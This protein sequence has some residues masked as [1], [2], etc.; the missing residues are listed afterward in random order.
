MTHYADTAVIVTGASSGLGQATA[1][2]LA[3]Q[4]RP[5]AV[6][7][8]DAARVEETCVRCREH[9]V[10]P[11]GITLD[12]GKRTAVSKA[13]EESHSELGTIG[14]L[15]MCHGICPLGSI[16]DLD[17]SILEECLNTN[18]TSL[19]FLIEEVLPLLRENQGGSIVGALSTNAIKPEP[20]NAQYSISKHGALG[21]MRV[22]AK[23]LGAE[24]IRVNTV[25]PGAMDTAMMKSALELAGDAAE[26]VKTQMMA[27][28]PLGYIA[29]PAEVAEVVCFLLS[30]KA[31]YVHGAEIA[32]DGGLLL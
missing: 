11:V 21:L 27:E 29:D 6:W 14:G 32:V 20:I 7:G 2:K 12:V 13:V 1:I 10:E 16:G 8:R 15:A 26:Q 9:G 30:E 18:L 4:G 23:T 3:E 28:I 19:A 31:S 5:V 25:C 24:G 22:T 17:F